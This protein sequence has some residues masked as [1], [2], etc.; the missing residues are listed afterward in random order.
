V[1]AVPRIVTV[2]LG[3]ALLAGCTATP[4]PS[5]PV[6][7]VGPA[8]AGLPV[9]APAHN[10]ADVMF[11]QM[12]IANDRQGLEI[13]GLAADRAVREE[14]KLL[15]AAIEATQRDEV[16]IMESWLKGWN[17]PT[18]V[19][20]DASAHADHGGLPATGA[21]QIAVLRAA[22]GADFETKF[23]SLLTG[24]QHSAVEMTRLASDDGV[25]P[26][27]RELAE[28]IKASRGEQ[29]AQMLRLMNS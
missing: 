19:G 29:I 9:A 3:V 12:M 26:D 23:L 4:A 10:A 22:S 1:T 28:R 13:T 7:A 21:A 27:T 2:L 16:T 25:N 6:E 18:T 17:E 24:H 8:G 14:V 15:A 5:A 11:L 20:H